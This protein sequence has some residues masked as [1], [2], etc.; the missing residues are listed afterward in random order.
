M[1]KT[2]VTEGSRMRRAIPLKSWSF[3]LIE[4]L[5]VIAIIGILASMLLPALKKARE[6]SYEITCKNNLKQFGTSL[7]IY[8]GDYD[9]FLPYIISQNG[10]VPSFSWK[11]NFHFL[12]LLGYTGGY[13]DANPK[14]DQY[15]TGVVICPSATEEDSQCSAATGKIEYCYGG[16]SFLN[17]NWPGAAYDGP[18]KATQIPYPLSQVSAFMD[19]TRYYAPGNMAYR[20]GNAPNVLFMDYH[21]ERFQDV[22]LTVNGSPFWVNGWLGY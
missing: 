5:V 13:L 14:A 17:Y 16:N 15:G 18:H 7:A 22:P 12:E 11:S 21:V 4:L 3:T 1:K 6:K 20:H 9:G 8:T 19:A 10:L 2:L